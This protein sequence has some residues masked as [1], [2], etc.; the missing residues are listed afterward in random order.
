ML[1]GVIVLPA[2]I[3]SL[4]SSSFYIQGNSSSPLIIAPEAA[5]SETVGTDSLW[6]SVTDGQAIITKYLPR[7]WSEGQTINLPEYLAGNKLIAVTDEARQQLISEQQTIQDSVH[8]WNA[9]GNICQICGYALMCGDDVYYSLKNGVLTLTGSGAM[10][11]YD[12]NPTTGINFPPWYAEKDTITQ[13]VVGKDI[14]IIGNNAFYGC[15]NLESL[16]F[17]VDSQLQVIGQSAFFRCEKL[18]DFVLP[19]SLKTMSAAFQFCRSATI[20]YPENASIFDNSFHLVEDYA[21]YR[22]ENGVKY[23]TIP[24]A[25]MIKVPENLMYTGTNLKETALSQI[26]FIDDE[27]IVQGTSFVVDIDESKWVK[28]ILDENIVDS[29]TYMAYFS[30]TVPLYPNNTM[31][32]TISKSFTVYSSDGSGSVEIDD[33]TYGDSAVVPV[34]GS[35][36]NGAENISYFYKSKNAADETYRTYDP[37]Q[38]GMYPCEVGDYVLKA[39]FPANENAGEAVAF[40]SFSI[41]PAVLDISMVSDIPD[42]YFTGNEIRPEIVVTNAEVLRLGYDYMIDSYGSNIGVGTTSVT[43]RGIGNYSGVVEKTYV[44]KNYEALIVQMTAPVDSNVTDASAKAS[45]QMNEAG[46]ISYILKSFE[47]SGITANDVLA[48]ADKLTL[49]ITAEQV[50]QAIELAFAGLEPNSSYYVYAVGN[51]LNGYKGSVAQMSFTTKKIQP[52]FTADP[53]INGVYGQK[54]SEMILSQPISILMLL[55]AIGRVLSSEVPS[56]GT[57]QVYDVVFTRLIL[58]DL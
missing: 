47:V 9:A 57:S 58:I 32:K 2:T 39:V 29:G 52:I 30:G 8:V 27:I 56:V 18:S 28:S 45:V 16:V 13:I 50:D 54:V 34:P 53:S 36:T 25:S 10:Y 21:A 23:I 14:T 7:Y 6:Y 43:I 1:T 4:A 35:T 3:T 44:I 17:E 5:Y 19:Q 11:D 46:T 26:G 15:A 12:K 22:V 33:W 49:N 31:E 24:T 40:A 48:D 42:Q 38:D 20:F 37:S 55:K 41:K 51:N